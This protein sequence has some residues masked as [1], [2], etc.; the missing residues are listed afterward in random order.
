MAGFAMVVGGIVGVSGKQ[1]IQVVA[2]HT[3]TN[4]EFAFTNQKTEK[5]HDNRRTPTRGDRRIPGL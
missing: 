4:R 3:Y 2:D 1:A 5:K